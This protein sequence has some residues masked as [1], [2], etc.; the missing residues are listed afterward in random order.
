MKAL[1]RKLLRDLWHLRGQ[2]I[3]IGLV[4]ACGVAVVRDD[5]RTAYESLALS[6]TQLLRALP[7]RRRL[8]AAEARARALRARDRRDSRRRGASRPAS[9]ST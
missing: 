1:D 3:A 4:V 7:L 8:R 9:S 5:A 2:V 6:Q